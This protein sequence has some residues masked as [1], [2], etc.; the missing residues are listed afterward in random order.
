MDELKYLIYCLYKST[1]EGYVY[2][3]KHHNK[4]KQPWF[5]WMR[6]CGDASPA[7]DRG[8]QAVP[9]RW[10]AAAGLGWAVWD[11]RGRRTPLSLQRGSPGVVGVGTGCLPACLRARLLSW[12][13]CVLPGCCRSCFR[14]RLHVTAWAD[15][16]A[17]NIKKKSCC[18]QCPS[19]PRLVLSVASSNPH[20]GQ[21]VSWDGQKPTGKKTNNFFGLR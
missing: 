18:R 13:G 9:A 5:L 20:T 7:A 14:M 17:A 16:T 2:S 8:S 4:L 1:H 19:A 3:L 12:E 11:S 21:L 6:R 15:L 10:R